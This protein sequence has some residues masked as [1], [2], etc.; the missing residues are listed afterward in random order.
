MPSEQIREIRVIAL[1]NPR[2]VLPLRSCPDLDARGCE[3]HP[4]CSSIQAR[5]VSSE[6]RYGLI[7]WASP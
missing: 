6:A 5:S 2:E 7:T 4:R 3:R 1:Q